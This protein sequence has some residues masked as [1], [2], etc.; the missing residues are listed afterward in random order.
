[1]RRKDWFIRGLR[2]P[3]ISQSHGVRD[4]MTPEELTVQRDLGLR[5]L[6]LLQPSPQEEVCEHIWIGGVLITHHHQSAI[7]RPASCCG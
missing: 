5:F 6:L 3:V 1:M 7:L 4:D 2:K